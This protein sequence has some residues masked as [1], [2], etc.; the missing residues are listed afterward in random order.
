VLFSPLKLLLFR[1]DDKQLPWSIQTATSWKENKNLN[2][3]N[4]LD[5]NLI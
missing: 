2:R 1:E 5:F 3:E 4:R